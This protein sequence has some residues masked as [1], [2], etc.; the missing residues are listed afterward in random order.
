MVTDKNEIVELRGFY[1][2]PLLL[3]E[4]HS[5][6]NQYQHEVG[7]YPS[8]LISIDGAAVS[9]PQTGQI[10]VLQEQFKKDLPMHKRYAL[11]N[12][13]PTALLP[14]SADFVVLVKNLQAFV[15]QIAGSESG[16]NS[17]DH[18][19]QAAANALAAELFDRGRRVITKR[20]I[21]KLLAVS[22]EWSEM[23]AAR[24]ERVIRKEW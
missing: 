17:R 13:Y 6:I 24:I 21:A 5:V 18:D 8:D 23:T 9:N 4:T 15:K 11:D 22:H 7:G 3:G 12:F 10:F 16:R 14:E 2:I 1:D 19:L 20:E